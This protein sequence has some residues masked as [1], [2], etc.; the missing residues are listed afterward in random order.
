MDDRAHLGAHRVRQELFLVFIHDHQIKESLN[1]G[2][3]E[4]CVISEIP[5]NFRAFFGAPQLAA[6]LV[7]LFLVYARQIGIPIGS[8]RNG[9]R[10][11]GILDFHC[12]ARFRSDLFDKRIRRRL[13]R[14]IGQGQALDRIFLLGL[15][16]IQNR[17]DK[18]FG[19]SGTHDHIQI[20][21]YLD[22]AQENKL[23]R[24][25]FL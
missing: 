19:I 5:F 20:I 22:A 7:A 4:G 14:D 23:F 17:A 18:S 12:P 9:R 3:Q 25:R 15:Q 16:M 2:V 8:Q 21:R 13:V 11:I 24:G 1:F 10:V 6:D